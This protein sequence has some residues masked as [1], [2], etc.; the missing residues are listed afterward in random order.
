[1]ANP[2][3]WE[4]QGK[5]LVR[6][7][8]LKKPDL[9]G[10]SSDAGEA[11]EG[12]KPS[13]RDHLLRLWPVR[14]SGA[15]QARVPNCRLPSDWPGHAAETNRSDISADCRTGQRAGLGYRE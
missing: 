1:M 4:A 13:A 2:F 7:D 12:G 9:R 5:P 6:P 8:G 11:R 15:G 3:T 10:L 14:D